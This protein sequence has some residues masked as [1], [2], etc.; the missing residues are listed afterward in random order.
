M[1]ECHLSGSFKPHV[2]QSEGRGQK[3]SHLVSWIAR[4]LLEVE[5]S[6]KTARQGIDVMDAENRK[7]LIK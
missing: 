4:S 1:C 7:R 2:E 5:G 3:M 6:V